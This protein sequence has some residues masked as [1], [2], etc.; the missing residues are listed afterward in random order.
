MPIVMPPRGRLT[1]TAA[2]LLI[3]SVPSLLAAQNA[4]PASPAQP[5]QPAQQAQPAAP[6]Q[7]A[8]QAQPAAPAQPAQQAQP[9]QPASQPLDLRVKL[10]SLEDWDNV[11]DSLTNLTSLVYNTQTGQDLG[12]HGLEYYWQQHILTAATK[13]KLDTLR[14]KAQKQS[15]AK[16]TAGLRKTLDEAGALLSA[17]RAKAFAI[18][19]FMNAQAPV[20][21]HQ[22]QLGPWLTRATDADRTGINDRVAATYARLSQE[23]DA[24]MQ[25]PEPQSPGATLQRFY[26]L[27]AE[28]VAFFNA[29]RERLVKAQAGMPSLVTVPARTRGDEP[30]P[31]PVPPTK[32]RDKPSLAANFPSSEK[33]YPAAAKQNDVEG[34][35]TLR[36]SISQT[37]CIQRAE[38]AGTSGVARLDESALDLAMAGTYVPGAGAGDKATAGTLLFRVKFEQPGVFDGAP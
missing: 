27:I 20:I 24:V 26:E 33:F 22:Y 6:A 3:S 13:E 1:A 35:V 19:T 25:L 16:D 5:T 28:P 30:C 10:T 2:L 7:P 34:A 38:V 11:I 32:G 29:E 37:G 9:A 14:D 21:Y 18:S 17:E 36:V 23:L 8:Q 4:P 15:V 12:G 31:A